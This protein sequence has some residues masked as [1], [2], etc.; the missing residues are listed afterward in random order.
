MRVLLSAY[1][2]EPNKGS[3]PGVGWNIARELAE[4]HDVWVITRADHEP[5]IRAQLARTPVRRLRVVAYELPWWL[6]LGWWQG[7][8]GVHGH[9]YLWQACIYPVARALH[10]AI[11]FDVVHHVTYVRYC[12]PSFL[13]LL[14]VPFVWGPVGGGEC[15]PTA[16]RR[17]L[18]WRGRLYELLRDMLRRLGEVDPFV[19][20]TARRAAMAY[21][22]TPET[23]DRMRK[24][25]ATVVRLCPESGLSDEELVTLAAPDPPRSRPTF[26]SMGRLLSW[27]GFHLGLRGFAEAKLTEADYWIVGD[28]PE[29]RRLQQLAESLGVGARVR[30]CGNLPRDQTLRKLKACVALVHPSLHDSGGWVCLET[31]AARKPVVCLELGGPGVQV[32][33]Q[34]GIK[35]PAISPA[36]VVQDL[37]QA[38]RQLVMDGEHRARMGE[39]GQ[40]RVHRYYRW[41]TRGEA[42]S[43]LYGQIIAQQRGSTNPA[44]TGKISSGGET[45]SGHVGK[46]DQPGRVMGNEV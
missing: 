27:K 30:F 32:T 13:S 36:Q 21:A 34:T 40:R 15:M 42:L 28:G 10:R 5:G 35:I 14:P 23:A 17:D 43:D 37:A 44:S 19:H 26:I 39:E 3:E 6:R 2:C 31:M 45:I 38:M 22:T 24:V 8:W 11:G 33:Q 12:A 29:R 1:A 18:A 16:F 9:Y 4:H 20:L 7:H 25:G 41:K 46:S